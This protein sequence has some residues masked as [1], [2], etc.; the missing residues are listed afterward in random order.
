MSKLSYKEK[1]DILLSHEIAELEY[2]LDA[3]MATLVPHPHFEIPFLGVAIKGWDAVY[4][5]YKRMLFRGGRD[6]NIQAVARVIADAD[7]VLIREAFV[8]F[9]TLDGKRKTGLYIVVISFDPV[10]KKITGE[11]MY[12]DT[13]YAELMQEIL[14]ADL[15]TIPGIVNL[16]DT[17]P[18]INEH[19]AF[20]AAEERGLKINNPKVKR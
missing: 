12:G 14:G 17:A 1:Y 15:D 11:R 3:T 18:I 5:M 9:D 10:L 20:A 13:V 4:E 6:R 2:N 8:S 7:N 19:D 16:T